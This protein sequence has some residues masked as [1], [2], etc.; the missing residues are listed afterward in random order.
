MDGGAKLVVREEHYEAVR[1][2]ILRHG[3]EFDDG[4]RLTAVDLRPRH[5]MISEEFEKACGECSD[6]C[7]ARTAPSSRKR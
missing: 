7:P 3:L 5:L 4:A 6:L 1:E 2:H